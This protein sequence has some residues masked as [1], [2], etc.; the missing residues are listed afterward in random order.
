MA[1]AAVSR[2]S[3]A[4]ARAKTRRAAGSSLCWASACARVRPRPPTRRRGMPQPPERRVRQSRATLPTRDRRS[5]RLPLPRPH[6]PRRV[7]AAASAAHR[8]F[9]RIDSFP[10]AVPSSARTSIPT[11]PGCGRQ[12]PPRPA[13]IPDRFPDYCTSST[14]S[15]SHRT[16][17]RSYLRNRAECQNEDGNR[18]KTTLFA[19]RRDGTA[20]V[21]VIRKP[22]RARAAARPRAPGPSHRR[23]PMRAGVRR[24]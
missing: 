5:R 17:G 13:D 7:S 24:G 1:V 14:C 3:R 23:R 12:G 15:G 2:P 16:S 6:L 22:R 11:W 18:R 4:D 10:A 21:S 8:H 20:C 19:G 9:C